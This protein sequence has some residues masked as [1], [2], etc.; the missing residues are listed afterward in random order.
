[1]FSFLLQA[2]L[3]SCDQKR[4]LGWIA[5]DLPEAILVNQR[6]VV[7][8]EPSSQALAQGESPVAFTLGALENPSVWIISG[9]AHLVMHTT[10][11]DLL[12]GHLILREGACLVGTDDRDTAERLHGGKSCG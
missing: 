11:K 1:M 6:S 2:T 5:L 10:C 8:Q 3:E 12:H 9:A 7:A 4:A